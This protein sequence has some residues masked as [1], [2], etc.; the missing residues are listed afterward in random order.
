MSVLESLAAGTP[1]IVSDADAMPEMWRDAAIML[2]RPIYL[3]EWVEKTDELLRNK[4]LW[5]RYSLLG[6]RKA[7]AFDWPLVA[8]KYLAIA[9]E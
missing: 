3:A 8:Q 2:K 6:K 5:N 7:Q 4:I 1:V 9:L